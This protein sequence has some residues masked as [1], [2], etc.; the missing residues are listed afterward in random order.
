MNIELRLYSTKELDNKGFIYWLVF[1]DGPNDVANWFHSEEISL[2]LFL[3]LSEKG[4]K[5]WDR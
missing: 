2:E 5:S 1:L 4:V 3:K